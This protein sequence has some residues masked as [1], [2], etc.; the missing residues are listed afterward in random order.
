MGQSVDI[1]GSVSGCSWVF[2]GCFLFQVYFMLVSRVFKA[3][4]RKFQ[5]YLKDCSYHPHG[6][7]FNKQTLMT[8]VRATLTYNEGG[9]KLQTYSG[10]AYDES[11]SNSV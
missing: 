4:K 5:G 9:G 7:F 6:L 10:I 3:V 2:Q 8:W 1:T 11:S